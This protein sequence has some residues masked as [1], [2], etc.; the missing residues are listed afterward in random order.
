MADLI[1]IRGLPGSGKTTL[2]K[3]FGLPY[4]EADMYHTDKDGNYNFDPSKVS[5]AHAW[6][7]SKVTE[8]LK[9][10]NSVV[11]SNTSTRESEVNKYVKYAE[12]WGHRAFSIIVENRHKGVSEHNVPKQTID[13]ME[14]R[15]HIQLRPL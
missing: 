13:E 11:V 14:A 10:G 2:A 3:M 9:Q 8:Q 1:I 4:F 12:E 15:F 7:F 6:C 5:D